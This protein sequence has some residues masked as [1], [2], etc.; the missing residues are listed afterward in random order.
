MIFSQLC[1]RAR[2]GQ[3][4]AS[5]FGTP[6]HRG[7]NDSV[8]ADCRRIPSGPRGGERAGARLGARRSWPLDRFIEAFRSQFWHVCVPKTSSVLITRSNRLNV[9][10]DDRAGR[11]RAFLLRRLLQQN[12]PLG[13]MAGYSPQLIES[14]RWDCKLKESTVGVQSCRPQPSSVILND[15]PAD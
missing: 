6:V 13:D 14:V 11:Q 5:A 9:S 2:L 7:W 15:R 4:I 12:L 8:V 1:R 3:G 10:S